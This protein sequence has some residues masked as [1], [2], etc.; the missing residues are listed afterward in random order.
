MPL[1]TAFQQHF[2]NTYILTYVYIEENFVN[3]LTV[4][5]KYQIFFHLVI[6]LSVSIISGQL[7]IHE[8]SQIIRLSTCGINKVYIDSYRNHAIY[9]HVDWPRNLPYVLLSKQLQQS[10]RAVIGISSTNAL[11]PKLTGFI[12]T[13]P[14]SHKFPQMFS[15]FVSKIE[16]YVTV[17]AIDG[18]LDNID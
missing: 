5:C 18:P 11:S 2:I 16:D 14:V 7:T 15:Y 17:T 12:W 13:G 3:D 9:H 8:V 6:W 10:W 4:Q 1:L